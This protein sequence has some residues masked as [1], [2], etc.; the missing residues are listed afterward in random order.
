MPCITV[1]IFYLHGFFCLFCTTVLVLCTISTYQ[2]KISLHGVGQF[3]SS[4]SRPRETER[5]ARPNKCVTRRW[6]A[7]YKV[8]KTNVWVVLYCV[9]SAVV[10]LDFRL[11]RKSRK[12]WE[13]SR[14]INDEKRAISDR[15]RELKLLV[16]DDEDHTLLKDKKRDSDSLVPITARSFSIDGV[17]KRAFAPLSLSVVRATEPVPSFRSF[18]SIV[19]PAG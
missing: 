12:L 1:Y 8:C 11:T 15:R 2:T 19:H 13:R 17:E 6:F 4:Q 14:W 7:S 16:V 10:V 5:P 9:V 18:I 3:F